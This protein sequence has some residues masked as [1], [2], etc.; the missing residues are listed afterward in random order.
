MKIF[1]RPDI[2]GLRALSILGVLFFH[3]E[4]DFFSGGYLGVD[5]FI[6]I[7]GFLITS[8]I[9]NGLKSNNFN[10]LNFFNRRAQRLLPSFFVV[11]FLSLLFS[12]YFFLPLD[13]VSFAKSSIS[14]TLFTSN[15]FFWLNSGY[16]SE[17]NTNPL[18]H[19]WSLSLEWQFY[20]FF[21]IFSFLIWKIFKKKNN[22][23][24]L[25]IF[26]FLFSFILSIMFMNRNMS[27]FL[28]PF[29]LYEFL[30]GSIIYFI[31]DKKTNISTNLKNFLSIIS[32]FLIVTSF[33]IFDSQA[34]V[35]GYV[36]LMPCIGCSLLI[37]FKDTVVHNLLKNKFLVF[38]G[39]ISYSLYL[40]H[41][42]IITFYSW[43][44]ITEIETYVKFILILLALVLS[45]LNFFFI[46]KP[47]RKKIF[48]IRFLKLIILAI[49]AIII[50][51]SSQIMINE[52][53]FPARVSKEKIDL[54]E[55]INKDSQKK[56]QNF[57]KKNIDL[58][59]D[60]SKKIKILV[61]GDS[62]GEDMFMALKQN[63]NELTDVEFL[64]FSQWCFQKNK[65][66]QIFKTFERISKRNLHC[67]NE[68][69]DIN[70]NLNLIKKSNFIILSSSWYND[71]EFYIEDIVNFIQDYTESEII[72]TSKTNHFPDISS[73]IKRI[74]L[75]EI[76]N[77]N[78]ITY[79][80]KHKSIYRLNKKLKKKADSLNIKY[81]DKTNIICPE[82]EKICK[83]YSKKQ[84]VLFISDD[85]HW[86][87][88][89]SKF[90]GNLIGDK[91]F[92]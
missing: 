23:L 77:I 9:F 56:R 70:K 92:K 76:E 86:T 27:F 20:F 13:L 38:L 12:Y 45:I 68:R 54:I 63:S 62:N 32:I 51:F 46:E 36:A 71:I 44:N 41:W 69:N 78:K 14:S 34:N 35:P 1:Y 50:L 19:T 48:Q 60:D 31:Q 74:N 7:S 24:K 26:I 37:Y 21:S 29:R 72:I 73:L 49:S 64:V 40:F 80:V 22:I 25:I 88:A 85:H 47:F 16:W 58:K 2:D 18:L 11:T 5:V 81:F 75:E 66:I 82:D 84:G 83:V 28:L 52:N 90:F 43:F 42:P 33:I 89:G 39:L 30:L 57:L 87:L 61:L 15:F 59:F 8:I 6:V 10:L 79:D 4:F 17:N 67:Q 53:G 65:F 55:T 91:L 3:F